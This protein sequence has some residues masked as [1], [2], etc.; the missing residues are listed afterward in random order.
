MAGKDGWSGT[1]KAYPDR[2]QI[3]DSDWFVSID[4]FA[5]FI[6]WTQATMSTERSWPATVIRI[7]T[8]AVPSVVLVFNLDD[9]MADDL[10]RGVVEPLDVRARPRRLAWWI[11]DWWLVW[12]VLVI[13]VSA[14]LV[15]WL[16][17][18]EP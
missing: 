8:A 12:V 15:G 10:L 11:A 16:V 1:C 14:G 4:E 6:P 2:G 17:S 3:H 18:G 9:A 13:G 5:I 7:T